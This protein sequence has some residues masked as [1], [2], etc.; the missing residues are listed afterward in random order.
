[1]EII[2]L[3]IIIIVGLLRFAYSSLQHKKSKFLLI[4]CFTQTLPFNYGVTILSLG[5]K[6]MFGEFG[7]NFR[8]ELTTLFAILL[9]ILGMNKIKRS[10][11]SLT[12]NIWFYVII[13]FSIISLYNISNNVSLSS[14]VPVCYSIQFLVL[15]KIIDSNFSREEIFL[16][17]FDGLRA[18]TLLQFS[19]CLLFPVLNVQSV[20][21]M[22]KGED[23]LLWAERREGYTSAIG[24]FSHP[25]QLALFSFLVSLFFL[26]SYL[27]EFKK[28]ISSIFFILNL[29]II[30]LT[31]SRTTYLVSV[32]V[33]ILLI[34]IRNNRKGV[35]TLSNIFRF[36]FFVT[37]LLVVL[38][39]T[40]LSDLFLKS[41][42]Q[43]QADNRLIHWALGYELWQNSMII[44]VGL[45][46]H[47]YKMSHSALSDPS[48]GLMDIDFFLSNPIHN[49]H[50]IIFA[51][52][53]LL[54]LLTWL[55]YFFS[56]INKYSKHL[57]TA[58]AIDNHFNF[59][60]IGILI[61]IF[62]YGFVGW[63]PFNYSIV[64]ISVFLGYFA[65]ISNTNKKA[66]KVN[67]S[68]T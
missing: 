31:F 42:S 65:R 24:S 40:P 18:A 8:L 46:S 60:Y 9:F 45:N 47:V 51:E 44:G 34:V 64:G 49:I 59:V 2:F 15:L 19:L 20:A 29:A 6:D 43:E 38:Y 7:N 25:G 27:N 41:D 3:A 21:Y 48:L 16:G 62:C 50:I 37:I 63:A 28:N 32:L 58:I 23:A 52:L 35:F 12:K 14:L 4:S 53:G 36:L 10:S 26:S 30:T 17:I 33:T 61:S 13:L 57:Q 11:F 56:N 1:M 66:L 68:L 22:F 67:S 5:K 54:G 55:Y 39:F